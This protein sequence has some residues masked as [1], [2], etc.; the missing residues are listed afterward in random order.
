MWK[1]FSCRK[2]G[3]SVTGKFVPWS[4]NATKSGVLLSGIGTNLSIYLRT[5]ISEKQSALQRLTRVT[6]SVQKIDVINAAEDV[7]YNLFIN[8]FSD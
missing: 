4:Y 6:L 5:M 8:F 1:C 2:F 7:Y 3:S